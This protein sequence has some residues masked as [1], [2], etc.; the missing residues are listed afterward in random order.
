MTEISIESLIKNGFEIEFKNKEAEILWLKKDIANWSICY[1]IHHNKINE[2]IIE[3]DGGHDYYG[4]FNISG[5]KY[6]EQIDNL[7][8]AMRGYSLIGV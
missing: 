2:F 4:S 3:A 1:R 5:F 7:I 8:N 6:I